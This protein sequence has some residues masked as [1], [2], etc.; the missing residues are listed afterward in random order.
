MTLEGT[1][2]W[3]WTEPGRD[4][5]VVVDPGPDVLGHLDD[6]LRTCRSLGVTVAA[7]LLT[8]HHDDHAE[9]AA[10]LSHAT[11]AP[12]LGGG[13][14]PLPEGDLAPAGEDGPRLRVLALP[15]HTSDSVGIVFPADRAIAT[16]D[17]IFDRG[18]AMIDWPDGSLADYLATLDRLRTAVAELAL[19]RILPGHGGTIDDP[20]GQ[21]ARY[22]A[23]R[24][25]RLAQVRAA[26]ATAGDDADAVAR[27]VYGDI[28]PGLREAMRRTVQAQL[29][30]LRETP[31]P[32]T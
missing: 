1:N 15:G 23:H 28:G 8:H 10:A 30:Y 2:T 27:A 22:Q 6:V 18:S 13:A 26:A 12:V 3:L 24:R 25:E 9:G 16:G 5:C 4:R 31:T 20:L 7:I 29:Q 11:G 14:G 17:L 19:A 21:I 32:A